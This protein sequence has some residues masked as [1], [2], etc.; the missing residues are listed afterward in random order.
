MIIYTSNI[1]AVLG[2]RAL[3]FL[4]AAVMDKFYLLQKGVALILIFIGIKLAL[5]MLG[6]ELPTYVS[7]SV[8]LFLLGG[9]DLG[10]HGKTSK[11]RANNL[12]LD[13][14]PIP[15]LGT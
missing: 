4:L 14:F 10:L 6:F 15:W 7:F 12:T 3:F 5:D 11:K 13:L 9:F 1:F 2:L 8:I